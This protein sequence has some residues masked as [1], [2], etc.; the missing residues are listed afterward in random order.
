MTM[1][2]GAR[3][4]DAMGGVNVGGVLLS[5]PF[6][7]ASGTSGHDVELSGY[8]PLRRLGAGIDGRFA[9]SRSRRASASERGRERAQRHQAW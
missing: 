6:M 1:Q 8:M 7:T 3:Y 2:R 5:N 4:L 9:V